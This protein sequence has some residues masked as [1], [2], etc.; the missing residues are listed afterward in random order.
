MIGKYLNKRALRKYIDAHVMYRDDYPCRMSDADFED[1]LYHEKSNYKT[2][3]SMNEFLLFNRLDNYKV[4]SQE[5]YHVLCFQRRWNEMGIYTGFRTMVLES[6]KP[7][8]MNIFEEAFEKGIYMTW[9][10]SA[11]MSGDEKF[12]VRVFATVYLTPFLK[13][14]GILS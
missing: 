13:E 10:E 6:C 4:T 7:V 5:E 11:P 9:Y 12:P 2:A 1:E 14:R 8:L 3:R